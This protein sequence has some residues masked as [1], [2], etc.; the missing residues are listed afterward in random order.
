MFWLQDDESRA[1]M[2][3]L[4]TVG[5]DSEKRAVEFLVMVARVIAQFIDSFKSE[6]R[7]KNAALLWDHD[8]EGDRRAIKLVRAELVHFRDV[9]VLYC[10]NQLWPPR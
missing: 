4:A 10:A 7:R 9:W 3:R 6:A 5:S 8:S 2:V 1:L